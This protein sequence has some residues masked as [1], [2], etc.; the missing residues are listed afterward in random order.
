MVLPMVHRESEMHYARRRPLF[1]S[2]VGLPDY[3][4]ELVILSLAAHANLVQTRLQS[5]SDR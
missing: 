5:A 3:S 4:E 2:G 1:F